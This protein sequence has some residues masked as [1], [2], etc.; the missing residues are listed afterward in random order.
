MQNLLEKLRRYG[1]R[2]FL[3]FSMNEFRLIVINRWLYGSYSQLKEDLVLDRL[4]GYKKRGFYVDVGAYDPYRFSNTMRFYRR[5]W[6]GINVEPNTQHWKRFE[7]YRSR[8]TNLNIGIGEKRGTFTFYS[9]N[10]PTL[11]TFSKKHA[12]GYVKEG[13]QITSSNT[14]PIYELGAILAIYAKG[15]TIDFLSVD[16]EGYEMH[17]LR[18]NNWK[19]FR[20]RYLCI[21]TAAEN[22]DTA[23]TKK[24]QKEVSAYLRSEGYNQILSNGLNSFYKDSHE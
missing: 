5:G 17:V 16:V 8:D 11:S 10:S 14:I 13:F 19:R 20:P 23:K 24:I 18:S 22:G 1:A 3:Q 7:T 12:L 15:K 21:E 9:I 2:R 4:L 6:R